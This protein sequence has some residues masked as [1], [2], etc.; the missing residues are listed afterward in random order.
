V[1]D[2]VI[3]VIGWLVL[4]WVFYLLAGRLAEPLR[5]PDPSRDFEERQAAVRRVVQRVIERNTDG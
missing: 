5:R 1:A 3:G 2:L 4:V